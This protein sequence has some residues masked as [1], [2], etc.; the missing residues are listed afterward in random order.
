MKKKNVWKVLFFA[1]LSI[2]I[3]FFF[4]ISMFLF[5]AGEEEAIPESPAEDSK[6]MSE[7][8]IQTNKNDLNELINY[9]IEKENLNGP[10]NYSVVLSDE[11]ELNGELNV[12]TSTLQL[13]MSFEAYALENGDLLLE[14]KSLSLGGIR[15][16]VS[17]VLK[18]IRSAYKLPEW[19]IIQPADKQIYVSLQSM[20]L[21]NDIQVRAEKFNLEENEIVMKMLVPVE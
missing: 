7:F 20:R 11:V 13:K 18:I 17:E 21:N 6:K 1:L 4:A 14:Q 10:I 2:N 9:Y 5:L 3:L 15:L 16:P 19:V 8:L 12:F